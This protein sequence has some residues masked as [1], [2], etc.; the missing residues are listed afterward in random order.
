MKYVQQF[1]EFINEGLDAKD[2]ISAN[3]MKEINLIL[4]KFA[5]GYG[6]DAYPK[7]LQD[8]VQTHAI[9]GIAKDRQKNAQEELK[10]LG[11]TK[12]RFVGVNVCFDASKML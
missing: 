4:K 9:Y 2:K 3:D 8:P 10:K 5:K 11:A 7:T 1:D 12:F 6:E